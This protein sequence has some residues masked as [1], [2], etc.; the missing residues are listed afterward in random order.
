MAEALTAVSTGS[1]GRVTVP[2]TRVD[3]GWPVSSPFDPPEDSRP[4]RRSSL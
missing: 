1:V 2:A 4:V 3:P